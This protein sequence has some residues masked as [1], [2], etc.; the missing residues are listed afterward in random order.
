M[1]QFAEKYGKEVEIAICQYDEEQSKEVTSIA[2]G[3]P[4]TWWR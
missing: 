3:D 2:A 4:T 1:K